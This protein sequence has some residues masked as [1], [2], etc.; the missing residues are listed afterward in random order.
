MST[1]TRV[2]R[3][4]ARGSELTRRHRLNRFAFHRLLEFGAM[5]QST[6]QRRVPILLTISTWSSRS[7]E[8]SGA[9]I[10]VWGGFFADGHTDF[11]LINRGRGGY[12]RA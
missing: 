11:V 7:L 10:M 1:I 2:L 5:E 6:L 4:P 9:S 8:E 3:R 12:E